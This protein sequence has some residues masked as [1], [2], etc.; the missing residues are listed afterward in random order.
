MPDKIQKIL[1]SRIPCY[2]HAAQYCGGRA[3]VDA[4]GDNTYPRQRVFELIELFQRSQDVG[5]RR[6]IACCLAH[7]SP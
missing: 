6:E 4:R 3:G 1:D 7:S 2:K 5:Q